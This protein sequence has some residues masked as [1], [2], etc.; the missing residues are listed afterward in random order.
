MN[1]V[2]GVSSGLG[3]TLLQF[4]QEDPNSPRNLIEYNQK[5]KELV[6]ELMNIEKL[7]ADKNQNKEELKLK[8]S[9]IQGR[10]SVL[11]NIRREIIMNSAK[12]YGNEDEFVQSLLNDAKKIKAEIN[13]LI[14][15]A[16]LYLMRKAHS[17]E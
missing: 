11:K 17:G 8:R 2:Q 5:R 12:W 10:L 9:V 13:N 1:Q 16:E 6:N 15:R 7:F 4:K 3:N 14:D